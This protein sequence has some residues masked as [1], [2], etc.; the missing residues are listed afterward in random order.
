MSNH[1]VVNKADHQHVKI[2]RGTSPELVGQQFFSVTFP[3]EFRS[4][5]GEYPIFFHHDAELNA[6]LPVALHGFENGS[7]LFIQNGKWQAN[8]LPLMVQRQ[9]FL[10]GQ[11]TVEEDGEAT[12]QRVV[13]LDTSSPR[14]GGEEGVALFDEHG[15]Q[16]QYLQQVADML[17]TI[18][19]GL[20]DAQRFVAKLNE[21]NLIEPVTLSITLADGN[22]HEMV[23][24]HTINEDRLEELDDATLRDLYKSKDLASIYYICASH[25]QVKRLIEFKNKQLG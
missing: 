8:Y 13:L 17:E 14:V 1:Q 21:L 3:W 19:H 22:K 16:S 5:Q 23:G 7:N 18:H 25:S 24:L 11:Q 9:P 12:Q 15:G 4:L 20:N 6:L 2:N 10:I